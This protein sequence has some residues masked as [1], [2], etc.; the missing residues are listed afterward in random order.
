M[1]VS[2]GGG[3]EEGEQDEKNYL[4]PPNTSQIRKYIRHISKPT[5]FV[6][7]L[8]R[9][10]K[11]FCESRTTR[12][13]DLPCMVLFRHHL[14]SPHRIMKA[15]IWRTVIALFQFSLPLTFRIGSFL[16]G[17]RHHS[18]PEPH[19]SCHGQRRRW[20][21]TGNCADCCVEEKDNSCLVLLLEY[22]PVLDGT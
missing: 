9:T 18:V 17:P 3:E 10:S 14:P 2:G 19:L 21:C 11:T 16:L 7:G 15:C 1:L 13:V 22:L 20:N 4:Y 5:K 12:S 8:Q 6:N